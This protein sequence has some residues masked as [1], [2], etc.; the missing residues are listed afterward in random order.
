MPLRESIH[1][2]D[3]I[4][5]HKLKGYELT[6]PTDDSSKS[7]GEDDKR[8]RYHGRKKRRRRSS[9]SFHDECAIR[10]IVLIG[11]LGLVM[12]GASQA[13]ASFLGVLQSMK[14]LAAGRF[15]GVSPFSSDSSLPLLSPS[16]FLPPSLPA[17][18]TAQY[19]T[20]C[21]S[22]RGYHVIANTL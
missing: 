21:T 2:L 9:Q 10:T 22:L 16:P 3:L 6:T 14:E 13:G 20:Y 4:K 5:S 15:M 12:V 7:M 17:A 1:S 19:S 11:I 8:C 18:Q